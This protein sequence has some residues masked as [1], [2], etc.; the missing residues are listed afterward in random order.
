MNDLLGVLLPL[1]MSGADIKTI[2]SHLAGGGGGGAS[3]DGLRGMMSA[4]LGDFVRGNGLELRPS[5]A[6]V[7]RNSGAFLDTLGLNPMTGFGQGM[8]NVIS[9][10][11]RFA[12]DMIGPMIGIQS[13]KS[14]FQ[15]IAN[16]ASGI[17]AA[18]GF[19][20]PNLL[21]PYGARAAFDR[22][23]ALA[24]SV[25]NMSNS[26]G[27]GYNVSFT[28]GLNMNEV[29]A[30]TQRLL[31][32]SLP[33]NDAN[34]KINPFGGAE[35]ADRFKR[36]LEELGSKFNDAAS[37]LAKVT[38]SVEEALNVMDRMAGGNFLGGSEED[39][40]K[41]AMRARNMAARV[42]VTSA[43]AGMDP[44]EAYGIMT[45]T[46][47]ALDSKLGTNRTIADMSGLNEAIRALSEG[48]MNAFT[49]WAANNPKA[50]KPQKMTALFGIQSRFTQF[51]DTSTEHAVSIVSA[52][53]DKF[54]EED[55][56]RIEEAFRSGHPDS[57]KALIRKRIGGV[58]FDSYMSNPS[59]IQAF[60][61][62]GD[63]ETWDRLA[64]SGVEGNLIQTAL[65]G[66]RQML[67]YH[68][69]DSDS[70]L[71][72][73]TGRKDRAGGWRKDAAADALRRLAVSEYGMDAG[74]AQ[75]RSIE[76]IRKYLRA[77]GADED[78]I[79]RTE[80]SAEIDSQIRE[81]DKSV[82]TGAEE[83]RAKKRIRGII[84]S[85]GVSKEKKR[86]LLESLDA[87]GADV[88]GIYERIT[89]AFDMKYD[90]SVTGGKISRAA[91]ERMKND[92]KGDRDFWQADA[93][94]D[95]MRKVFNAAR[96]RMNVANT[97][98]F[99][100][101]MDKDFKGKKTDEEALSAFENKI[102]ELEK[103]GLDL[104]EG[105]MGRIRKSAYRNAVRNMLNGGVGNVKE[106]DEN[107]SALVDIVTESVENARFTGSSIEEA[108]KNALRAYAEIHGEALGEDGKKRIEQLLS[109]ENLIGREDVASEEMREINRLS[110]GMV[111][112]S[113][114]SI[115]GAGNAE[116]FLKSADK[117][118][119]LGM[120]DKDKIDKLRKTGMKG[121]NTRQ[122]RMRALSKLL[123]SRVS[124]KRIDK[125]RAVLGSEN[126]QVGLLAQAATMIEMAG[127]DIHNEEYWKGMGVDE[128]HVAD[129]IT[130][131]DDTAAWKGQNAIS[132]A[133]NMGSGS[134]AKE[135]INRSRK[136]V[137]DLAK[138][139]GEAEIT[140]DVLKKYKD[141]SSDERRKIAES[142]AEI[143]D[144][145]GNKVFGDSKY[146]AAF[147]QNLVKEGFDTVKGIKDAAGIDDTK[148]AEL[149]KGAYRQ[150][151]VVYDIL[152]L[153]GKI[154]K[155]LEKFTPALG[156][157]GDQVKAAKEA[158]QSLGKMS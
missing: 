50:S 142:L 52:H 66:G 60:R 84:G 36:R 30:V 5:D 54:T 43:M 2:F 41:I 106:G 115:F 135:E 19:G 33:Y 87:E 146:A 10:L 143:K 150:D 51:M 157:V 34:G 125:I 116:D 1:L 76:Q 153:V 27:R 18:A 37:M 71:K 65:E 111:S 24:H 38:G 3:Y 6:I 109:K 140:D 40:R 130:A 128:E 79:E 151:S 22:S 72:T 53:K 74:Y 20:T 14:F 108:A 129:F 133:I 64:M 97:F 136:L 77:Y 137:R 122:G 149:T 11:Y 48:A 93:T 26:E 96:D 144:S 29:G 141:G 117:L 39:A 148:M 15:Q 98:K 42:R 120:L 105:G 82:M 61:L 56:S 132:N 7:A 12:P 103:S 152:E 46:Q 94:E 110:G 59:A 113:I 23:V 55:M 25:F 100:N 13:P 99:G 8:S 75:G 57:A 17:N 123:G 90:A 134:I 154:F 104:G 114:D 35:E 89:E 47:Q 127:G 32:S 131:L 85:L 73:L 101:L 155:E 21:N 28:H 67:A 83:A 107:F 80:K 95:Q 4:R 44:Q 31:S 88:S 70:T 92:L 147:L 91:A 118:A 119:G 62:N 138:Y 78:E 49:T 139:M 69:E 86:E 126:A 58:A 145:K 45:S 156:V 9:S 68:F 81:I 63:R 158:T 102:L 124:S 112:E 16:G 121:L